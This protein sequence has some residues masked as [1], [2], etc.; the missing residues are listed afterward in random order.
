MVRYG[1]STRAA[2]F[3]V[4]GGKARALLHGRYNVSCQDIQA[5]AKPVLRHRVLTNFHAESESVT[6]EDIIEKLTEAVQP[7]SSGI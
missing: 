5:L 3:L 2:Q 4:L 7:P 6:I 1:A